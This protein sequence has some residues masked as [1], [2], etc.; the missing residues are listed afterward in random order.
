MLSW[1][2]SVLRPRPIRFQLWRR[3]R[4]AVPVRRVNCFLALVRL[5]SMRSEG[6]TI[7]IIEASQDVWW[8]GRIGSRRGLVPVSYVERT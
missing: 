3:R 4:N 8:H 1:Y 5:T 7:E 6:E 2:N